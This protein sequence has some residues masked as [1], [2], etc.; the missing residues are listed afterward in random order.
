MC[1]AGLAL[2]PA[3]VLAAV[4]GLSSV[5][6]PRG[7]TERGAS[8]S[9]PSCVS[10]S[11]C[12][13]LGGKYRFTLDHFDGQSLTA[14][15]SP[16][17]QDRFQ[18][19]TLSCPTASF[20]MAVG[21]TFTD[22][23]TAPAGEVW[24]GKRW[25]VLTVPAG[26]RT[27]KSIANHQ[28]RDVLNTE[29]LDVSCPSARMCIAVGL[30]F[31]RGTDRGFDLTVIERW[32]G[33]RWRLEFPADPRGGL[34]TVSCGSPRLCVATGFDPVGH[35]G[36]AGS[37]QMFSGS[38][39]TIVKLPAIAGADILGLDGVS[40]STATHCVGVGSAGVRVRFH[41]HDVATRTALAADYSDHRWTAQRLPLAP[42]MKGR[43]SP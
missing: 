21:S 29:L 36:Y 1:V 10:P 38:R 13:V 5:N 41:G 35:P 16:V 34:A 22:G 18:V 19:S 27:R 37:L 42:G 2:V 4:P 33:S 43:Y 20:C 8:L 9:T 7:Q 3:A 39:W 15:A 40:C 24:N 25:R 14:L 32:D 30:S 11:S 28:P 23:R 31:S 26:P 6:A 12:F 17:E